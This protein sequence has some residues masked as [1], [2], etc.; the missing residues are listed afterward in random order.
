MLLR[1]KTIRKKISSIIVLS[2]VLLLFSG[3][4][5][6]RSAVF[7]TPHH[8]KQ[9]YQGDLVILKKIIKK[10]PNNTE[11]LK[12]LIHLAFA[13]EKFEETVEYAARY[14][15][16]QQN[17]SI[18]AIKISALAGQGKFTE[19]ASGIDS[20]IQTYDPGSDELK[21]LTYKKELFLK[22]KGTQ[23]APA[24]ATGADWGK[25][26]IIL[27]IL[28]REKLFLC[29]TIKTEKTALY[30]FTGTGLSPVKKIPAYL[31]EIDLNE[32]LFISVS[33]DSRHVLASVRTGKKSAEILYREYK[34]K[35]KV[36][37][38][39][40][41]I[42]E[43][44]PGKWN[45]F[46]NF[47]VSPKTILFSSNADDD[48]GFDIYITTRNIE[49][50]WDEPRKLESVNTPFDEPALYCHLDGKT[51]YFSSNGRPGMGGYDIFGARLVKKGQGY[52]VESIANIQEV[53]TFRNEDLPLL[54]TIG[55]NNG[56][57][58]FAAADDYSVYT[59][60]TFSRQP[61]QVLLFDGFIYGSNKEE[62]VT[63]ASVK[64]V[65]AQDAAL[66]GS[67][68]LS[69]NAYSDGFFGLSLKKGTQYIVTIKS[70][71]YPTFKQTF[72]T[73]ENK[74]YKRQNF[75]LEKGK[76][77]EEIP[78]KVPDD[79]PVDGTV[80]VAPVEKKPIAPITPVQP[81]KPAEETGEVKPL[82]VQGTALFEL[83]RVNCSRALSRKAGSLLRKN[84]SQVK[85]VTLISK[86][87]AGVILD[88]QGKKPY[89]Y[90]KKC[91]FK[92]GEL[93]SA[94]RVVTGSITGI[95]K[96]RLAA[97][98]KT[99]KNQYIL[100]RKQA[101]Y[102]I[103]TIEIFDIKTGKRVKKIRERTT[104]ARL[105]NTVKKISKK[106]APYLK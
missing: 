44:N 77:I 21:R 10:D 80:A 53:N 99:G 84:L 14:L 25:G 41:T 36:W 50:D 33:P 69:R 23:A 83:K 18:A 101:V 57:A 12:R 91:A 37:G 98:G 58:N 71:D 38:D 16:K 2:T 27:S 49:G 94:K 78:E 59:G 75:Y 56:F 74:D 72:T 6:A 90:S 105:K 29:Y 35:F 28:E 7:R 55:A 48:T 30:A 81:V 3:I 85:A 95:K 76:S 11:Q 24:Q 40:E 100:E 43:L 8:E 66:H 68:V 5:P 46:G 20:Y 34:T 32:C 104:A 87:E 17:S 73:P 4:I 93:L 13:L 47:V 86:Q 97:L 54:F 51:L 102:Y 62:A 31:K 89:C 42:D 22:S 88:K 65:R 52:S 63:N 26:K 60:K 64:I 67:P 19:A 79:I 82:V 61:E 106:S 9:V 92:Y 70:E 96:K 39:W 15:K 45:S 1:N 103:V